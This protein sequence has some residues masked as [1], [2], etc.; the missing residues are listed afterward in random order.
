M[1]FDNLVPFVRRKITGMMVELLHDPEGIIPE[2]VTPLK[3][4]FF[5][6]LILVRGNQDINV[7]PCP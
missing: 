1:E 5:A 6:I 7:T 3:E 4:D 2:P